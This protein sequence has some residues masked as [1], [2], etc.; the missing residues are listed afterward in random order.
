M[1]LCDSITKTYGEQLVLH[2]I[3]QKF[4]DTGF[5]LLLGES[6]SGKTTFMN[7]LSGLIPF[8]SGAVLWN[9]IV[10]E[11]QVDPSSTG[12]KYDYITQDA[13]FVDYLT[14]IENLR[15]V[16]ED[17]EHIMSLLSRFDM[18]NT[19][20][21]KITTLSGGER[22]RLALIRSLLGNKKVLFLD[23]PTASLDENNKIAV[24]SLLSQLK[25]DVLILCA[26]H[27]AIA[28]DYADEI[29][30]FEKFR[31]YNVVPSLPIARKNLR[32]TNI[33]E[34]RN[35][36]LIPFLKKWFTSEQCNRK[37]KVLFTIFLVFTFCLCMLSDTPGHKMDATIEHIYKLNYLTVNT[38][39]GQNWDQIAPNNSDELEIVL[40]YSSSCPDGTEQLSP[41]V[42]VRPLPDY[43]LVLHTLPYSSASFRLSDKIAAGTYFTDTH[44]IILSWEM[45]CLL[46]TENP[47]ELVGNHIQKNVYGF[48]VVDFEIVGIFE[49]LNDI[50]KQYLNAAVGID[51]DTEDYS[52]LFFINGK[53]TESLEMDNDF[54]MGGARQRTYRIYFESFQ[55][56]KDYYETHIT[57]LTANGTV[58]IDYSNIDIQLENFFVMLCYTL[59]PVAIF[60]AL[61]AVLFYV[62]LRKTEYVYNNKFVAVFEYL[63]YSKRKVI[64]TF[65]FLNLCELIKSCCIAFILSLSI[66]FAINL[67]NKHLLFANFK[68]FSFNP[69]LI[70]SYF[71]VIL[72]LS[73]FSVNL[74][75][76]K[77]RVSS[78]YE[79]AI[80]GRDLL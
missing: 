75:F 17:D 48:G 45:A 33:S 62:A 11:Q 18:Q 56:M 7:I 29:I 54:Y 69:I 42:L 31:G 47:E 16:S 4:N 30:Y 32:K 67:L 80:S 12:S 63:G 39:E 1:I 6:G 38:M 57:T 23:E 58:S 55:A 44:Q 68:V 51:Y 65:I 53:I 79:I 52:N 71:T 35:Q 77:V 3:S 9:D 26:T 64:N 13:Y 60:M 21:Q 50:D 14:V 20:N 27:D 15:M 25:K 24:F 10:Y 70:I 37:S 36:P 73:W 72:A 22:Q 46:S 2:Q 49:S 8:D 78:W 66:A 34:T 76:R 61:F 41:D 43:E 19:A 74:L 40:D 5:Y 28:A 59:L